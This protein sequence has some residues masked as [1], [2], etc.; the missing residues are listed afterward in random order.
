MTYGGFKMEYEKVFNIEIETEIDKSCIASGDIGLN[1]C[2]IAISLSDSIPSDW[3]VEVHNDH[4]TI[5]DEIGQQAWWKN[6][7]SVVEW[8]ATFD[9]QYNR[10]KD[11]MAMASSRRDGNEDFAIEREDWIEAPPFRIHLKKMFMVDN[12]GGTHLK[13]VA[14]FSEVPVDES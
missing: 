11:A 12:N 7:E 3:Q 14:F 5:M 2:P 4:I 8:I 10:M 6:S 13:R 9:D 1:S